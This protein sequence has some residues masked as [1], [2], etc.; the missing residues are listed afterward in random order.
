[1]CAPRFAHLRNQASARLSERDYPTEAAP[2]ANAINELAG[3]AR[4]RS[5]TSAS[6]ARPTWH[7]RSKPRWPRSPRK[8]GARAKL[9]PTDAADG[10]GP[11]HR[12]GG[13]RRGA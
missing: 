8:A 3:R 5:R 10:L 12:G 11:R 4:K 1:M 7:T 6:A 2:L 9:A 13:A